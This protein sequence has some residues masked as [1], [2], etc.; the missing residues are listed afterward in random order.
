VPIWDGSQRSQRAPVAHRFTRGWLSRLEFHGLTVAE[1]RALALASQARL[2][3]ELVV[4]MVDH[5][6]QIGATQQYIDSYYE[7][8][9]DV[10]AGIDAYDGPGLHALA[11]CPQLANVRLFRLG[12][13]VDR[14]E[15]E[16]YFNC[17]TPGQLAHHVVKQM[18]NLEEL[19]LL[20]HLV[21]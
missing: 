6:I 9:P 19:Y 20:A 3:R 8:G 1:A 16:E 12:E 5:E 18:P 14:G 4:E 13:L 21:D 17:H 2:L 15:R 11:R 7:P 10:P